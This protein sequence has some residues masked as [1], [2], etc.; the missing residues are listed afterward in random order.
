MWQLGIRLWVG[1]GLIKVNLE[2]KRDNVGAGGGGGS[3]TCSTC[4]LAHC[5]E[6]VSGTNAASWAEHVRI[7][8]LYSGCKAC[9]VLLLTDTCTQRKLN[10]EALLF[11]LA[12]GP[13]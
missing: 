11:L 8:G 4:I 5:V 13:C 1:A 6:C 2:F 10:D 12:A 7:L 9:P 3:S